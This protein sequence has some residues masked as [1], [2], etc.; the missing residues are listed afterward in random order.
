MT[1]LEEL[2]PFLHAY[3]FLM[4]GINRVTCVYRACGIVLAAAPETRPALSAALRAHPGFGLV[5]RAS[6]G[7]QKLGRVWLGKRPWSRT[8]APL[9]R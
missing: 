1:E 8:G 6:L 3:G 2:L 5:L 7:W 4:D 9:S